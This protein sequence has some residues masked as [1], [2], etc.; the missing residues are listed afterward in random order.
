MAVFYFI[1]NAINRVNDITASGKSLD[2][3]CDTEERNILP[4]SALVL[5][6]MI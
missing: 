6:S 2:N 4:L 1:E 3:E 5:L